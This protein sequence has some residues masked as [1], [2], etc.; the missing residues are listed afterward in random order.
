M[1]RAYDKL[2][3]LWARIDPETHEEVMTYARKHYISRAEAIRQL[4]EFGLETV[5]GHGE[6]PTTLHKSPKRNR[7]HPSNR[8]Y[9]LQPRQR[10]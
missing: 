2:P 4:V 1:A 8:A 10:G 7:M 3:L 5:N 9:E 6:S